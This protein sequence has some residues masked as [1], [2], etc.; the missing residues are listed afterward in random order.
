[1]IAPCALFYHRDREALERLV[2][3]CA[4][5]THSHP[6]GIAGAILQARQVALALARREEPLDPL[7]FVVELR[8][9]TRSLQLRH[10]LRAVEE[11][12]ERRAPARVVRD[13]LGANATA[14]GSVPTA[15]YC[16]LSQTDS[17]E[18]A[19]VFAIA[20][21]GETDSVGA[22]TGAIAGAHHGLSGIP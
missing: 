15:L 17:F 21:G 22:L 18:A 1:R 20:L 8:S 10:K 12:V 5:V 13:R 6:L 9:T 14:L 2:E 4:A 3:T 11:C 19:L 7:P 16:F